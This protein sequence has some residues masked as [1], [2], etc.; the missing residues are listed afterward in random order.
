MLS[1]TFG[2]GS[3]CPWGGSSYYGNYYSPYNQMG[4]GYGSYYP[5]NVIVINNDYYNNVAYGKR[6]S[7]SSDLNNTI[8]ANNRST[9]MIT[10]DSQGRVRGS[11]GRVSSVDDTNST[12]GNYYQSGWRTNPETNSAAR[13]NWSSS[14]RSGSGSGSSNSGF[15][16]NSGSPSRTSSS[17]DNSSSR[18]SNFG[19]G[20]SS[21]NFSSGGGSRS[22]GSAVGS[23]GSSS[24]SGARR[25]RD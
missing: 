3:Y 13:S 1:L 7:R 11:G 10:T 18:T 4:M 24:S 21:S 6:S 14:G 22:S 17:Y 2:M 16:N 12:S 25:G 8:N 19:G 20:N 9:T 15:F 5:N 23:G